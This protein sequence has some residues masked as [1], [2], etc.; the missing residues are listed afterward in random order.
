MA[1]FLREKIF[2]VNFQQKSLLRLNNIYKIY[3]GY[4][5]RNNSSQLVQKLKKLPVI[6]DRT[7][8]FR[9]NN[10]SGASGSDNAIVPYHS[11]PRFRRRRKQR[12]TASKASP[13]SGEAR[14]G[15]RCENVYIRW[16][17]H[18]GCNSHYRDSKG[19]A[20][21]RRHNAAFLRAA[22]NAPFG[23]GSGVYQT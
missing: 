8:V 13:R 17:D 12:A 3:F 7:T 11:A 22:H 14:R 20:F 16:S 1:F 15:S 5:R 19:A 6:I 10:V 2:F 9:S 23:G 4:F 21:C 18:V